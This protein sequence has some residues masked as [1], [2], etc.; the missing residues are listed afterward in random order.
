[1]R[2]VAPSSTITMPI[3]N[4]DLVA[5]VFSFVDLHTL[6]ATCRP[7]SKKHLALADKEVLRRL[8]AVFAWYAYYVAGCAS[9]C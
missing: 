2:A 5:H 4:L 8:N 3:L 9:V 7:S 6:L 1:M